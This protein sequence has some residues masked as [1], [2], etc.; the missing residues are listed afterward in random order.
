MKSDK[1]APRIL[2]TNAPRSQH[3]LGV[4]VAAS[5][6]RK[7]EW[8]VSL[9]ISRRPAELINKVQSEWFDAVGISVSTERQLN[10]LNDFL[11]EM[12]LASKNQGILSL[13]GGPAVTS[14][15]SKEIA[16]Q[17]CDIL[18]EDLIEAIL[19]VTRRIVPTNKNDEL[20]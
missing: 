10:N 15:L 7:H 4:I 14:A 8:L 6:F 19:Q 5:L 9:E 11:K 1:V 13:V 16:L 3:L 17:S 2:L 12:K 20:R 18:A